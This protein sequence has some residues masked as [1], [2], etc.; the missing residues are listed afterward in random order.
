[1]CGIP[2]ELV[3]R[4]PMV[5]RGTLRAERNPHRGS[6]TQSALRDGPRREPV[7]R[8]ILSESQ[9]SREPQSRKHWNI[10]TP[11]LS[12]TSCAPHAAVHPFP[13]TSYAILKAGVFRAPAPEEMPKPDKYGRFSAPYIKVTVL[14]SIK[15]AA[16]VRTTVSGLKPPE[17]RPC[18][19]L[20]P[21]SI[22][23]SR[24]TLSI[25]GTSVIT[26]STGR[27]NITIGNSILIPAL[28]TAASDTYELI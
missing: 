3:R 27:I 22:F 21:P 1:M 28:P 16:R 7:H 10:L 26:N 20:P 24:S 2:V 12:I 8:T 25:P 11:S 23:R 6:S 14:F 19:Y 9:T 4:A 15:H 5:I 18:P 17:S 13:E